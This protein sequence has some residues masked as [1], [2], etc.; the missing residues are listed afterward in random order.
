M[1]DTEDHRV[2]GAFMFAGA[3]QTKRYSSK[4]MQV[5]NFSRNCFDPDEADQISEDMQEGFEL[6]D[7]MLTL[8]KMLRPSIIPDTGKTFVVGDWSA[9]EG[10][11]LPWLADSAG[12]E[13]VLDVF[14][15]DEDI[16]LHTAAAMRIDDRQIGKVA[17]LALGYQGGVNA[18][19]SMGRNYGLY[20]PESQTKMIV[21]KWRKANQ[22]AV[23]FWA[24][25]EKAA[26]RALRNPDKDF[27]VGKLTYRYVSNLIGGTL[28]CILP[29]GEAIQ[30]PEARLET[31]HNSY[32]SKTQVTYLKASITPAA[33]AKEW[34]RGTLYGGLMAENATQA[35]AASLLKEKLRDL[36]NEPVVMHVHDEIILEVLLKNADQ[37]LA[38]LQ[39]VMEQI[40]KW[41]EGLPLKA[42]PEVMRRYGK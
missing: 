3:G 12:A 11:F 18:F 6:D 25:L 37:Y 1:A 2:R 31:T 27:I 23:K 15:N 20:L 13:T 16:Y 5:H 4:G 40:P 9:I 28:L 22:W 8:S 17:T 32:G 21:D 24:Q 38:K 36:K 39:K 33:N 26:V 14:R 19:A 34:P 42:E 29:N 7:T 35:I 41:A 30:Y 10:R